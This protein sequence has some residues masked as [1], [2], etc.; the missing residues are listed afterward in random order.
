M[1]RYIFFFICVFCI[2]FVSCSDNESGKIA[3]K[4]TTVE[5]I[6]TVAR[7]SITFILGKDQGQKNP[8]YALANSYY[9]INKSEK[10]EIVIDTIFSLLEVRNFLEAHPPV[11]GRPWGLINLVSHGNEFID[12]SVDVFKGGPRTSAE[13]LLKAIEDSVFKPL[14]TGIVDSKSQL[15]IHGCAVGQNKNLLN[16]LGIAFGGQ[17]NPIA[18]KASKLFEYYGYLVMNKNPQMIRHYFARVWY[19]FYKYDSLPDD[20]GLVEQFRSAYPADDVNWQ[21]GVQRQYQLNPSEIYHITFG[22]PVVWEEFYENKELM[23]VLNTKKKQDDWFANNNE[24]QALINKTRIPFKYFQIKYYNSV[25]RDSSA[26]IYAI[27]AKA[28]V[29]V[30]CIIKPLIAEADSLQMKFTPFNPPA[31]DTSYF[32]FG[33]TALDKLFPVNL[34]FFEFWFNTTKADIK[35]CPYAYSKPTPFILP[36]LEDDK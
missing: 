6:D 24:F 23:P 3:A 30:I 33:L 7:T 34:N 25:Y 14:S 10:T 5:T 32:S 15:F 26:F 8:Y 11:N 19:G 29:G 21:E 18:V 36:E 4:S 35:S 20:R 9:R 28:R 13:S 1:F 17:N 12:L 27:K 16:A 22:L 2:L 31:D